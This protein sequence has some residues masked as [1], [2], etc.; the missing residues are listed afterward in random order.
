M[1]KIA[2]ILTVLSILILLVANAFCVYSVYELIQEF[3]AL[4]NDPEK[5]GMDYFGLGW[6]YAVVLFGI[7][8]L[9]GATAAV[10][11]ELSAPK[12]KSY[13]VSIYTAAAYLLP[14]GA[15]IVLFFM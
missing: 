6:G 4:E 3:N 10:S 13:Y 9:G 11:V 2:V 7:S 8:V 1:K 12:S 14:L 15:S 5:G